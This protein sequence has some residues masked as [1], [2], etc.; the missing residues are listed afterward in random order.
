MKLF[1]VLT[2][3]KQVLFHYQVGSLVDHRAYKPYTL[4]GPPAT[5]LVLVILGI[6]LLAVLL[7]NN[8]L[9]IY[10]RSM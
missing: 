9:Y 4:V 5:R 1:V 10:E 8:R 2:T 3:V 7:L 6:D